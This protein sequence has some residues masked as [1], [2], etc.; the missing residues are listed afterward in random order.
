MRG[1]GSPLE[2]GAAL[3]DLAVGETHAGGAG[4]GELLVVAVGGGCVFGG[5]FG[6][7]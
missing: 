1:G 3:F 4:G 2:A 5:G 7:F 6:D